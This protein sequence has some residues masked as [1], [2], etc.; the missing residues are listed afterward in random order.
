[1]WALAKDYGKTLVYSGPLYQKHEVVKDTIRVSFDHVGSGLK[2]R[3]ATSLKR[4]EMCGADRKWH[5]AE[6]KI[7]GKDTIVLSS[8][9]VK[10]PVAAR[11]AWAANPEGANLINSEN[12]PASVFSTENSKR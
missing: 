7:E 2:A 6:A 4:F 8:K 1:L 5:W 12:L 11:Y 10:Q 3:D 9:E